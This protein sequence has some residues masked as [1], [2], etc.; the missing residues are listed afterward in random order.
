MSILSKIFSGS[1]TGV[2]DSLGGVIDQF[3]LSKEEK[4]QFKLEMHSLLMQK[5]KELEETYRAELEA[6]ADIIKSEMEQDDL[7]TKRARPSIIYGGLLFIFIV[8]VIVPLLA[9]IAG[10]P[11]DS[12]PEISLPEEFWWAW[13]TV[14]GV[15]GVGRSAE[16][17]GTTNNFTRFI[18]GSNA[19]KM[20]TTKN[21]KG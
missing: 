17:M 8:Y 9:I 16:K 7:F 3:S 19:G 11:A 14:V 20:N 18:T 13:G 1:L 21:A 2:I 15:Y 6:R 5:E 4:Q 10:T 12:I